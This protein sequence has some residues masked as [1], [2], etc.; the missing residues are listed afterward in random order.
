MLYSYDI[1]D[2]IL[3]RRTA[4]PH[5]IFALMQ[6][7]LQAGHGGLPEEIASGFYELRIQ[8]ERLARYF[9]REKG[10]EE[11][12]IDQIYRAINSTGLL[13]DQ[14]I[15]MLKQIEYE[16]EL[17]N[18]V[19]IPAVT[20]EVLHRIKNGEHVIFISD[21]Y[22]DEEHIYG[23]LEKALP[24]C[25]Q[26]K[27]YVSCDTGK[28]KRT[29]NMFSFVRDMEEVHGDWIHTGDDEN[30]DY[31]IPMK[32]G[33][34]ARRVY[35][36]KLLPIEQSILKGGGDDPSIQ[37]LVGLSKNTRLLYGLQGPGEIGAS[38]GGFLVGS[39]VVW[40]LHDAKRRGIKTLYFIARDGYV[41][42]E[43]ADI[44]IDRFGLGISTKYIYG[45]RKAWRMPGF[46]SEDMD[47]FELLNVSVPEFISDLSAIADIFGISLPE[48]RRFLPNGLGRGE[49][50]LSRIDVDIIFYCL[51]QSED[52]KEYLIEMNREKRRMVCDY[53]KQEIETKEEQVVFVEVGGTGYTQN[54]A[55]K[56]LREF[57]SGKVMTYYFQLYSL[58]KEEKQLF[59]NFI[60]DG[61][62][63]KDAI[64]PLC[65][66]LH[67]QT[68]GYIRKGDLIEPLTEDGEEQYLESCG[69]LNYIEG[70][71]HYAECYARFYENIFTHPTNR[72]VIRKCWDYYTRSRDK[73]LWDFIG[74]IPFSVLGNDGRCKKYAPRLGKE[75]IRKIFLTHRNEPVAWS[76]DGSSLNASLLRLDEEERAY[77]AECRKKADLAERDSHRGGQESAIVRI[78]AKKVRKG[79]RIALYGAG[80]VGK[81][82]WIQLNGN[83]DWE[84]EIW[85]DRQHAV[86][87][88]EGYPVKAPE[89]LLNTRYDCILIAVLDI[90]V[91][92]GIKKGLIQMGIAE[93]RIQWISPREYLE[94]YENV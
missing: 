23:M 11:V 17:E 63:I 26:I 56:L 36:E 74:E 86:Y 7:R 34:Q 69:Y 28:T 55:E 64:E 91:K 80:S 16:T 78:P 62:Y 90:K 14:D 45:S 84:L 57:Y 47:V 89:A 12:T 27:L 83:T 32:M 50:R 51:A 3:T 58:N 49:I 42:K 81:A 54:C 68:C 19:P 46:A 4:T 53:L 44:F 94:E 29:G 1:F 59:L 24:N 39:Y 22:W 66:A 25:R 60:P 43:I 5:G 65:R 31:F 10:S 82:L 13:C 85:V 71:R 70:L 41:L 77:L 61:H 6:K 35:K 52:F 40:L 8:G 75:E 79:S 15:T 87:E 76:Y 18:I 48:L 2:T 37:L 9:L 88:K 38:L 93:E 73:T 21:M 67:G 30:A 20:E 33:I 92:E 72:K